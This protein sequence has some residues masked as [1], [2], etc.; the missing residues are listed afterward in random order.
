[1]PREVCLTKTLW[2]R[3]WQALGTLCPVDRV[4]MVFMAILLSYMAVSILSGHAASQDTNTVDVMVRTS[5]SAIFGYFISGNF[6]KTAPQSSS[7]GNAAPSAPAVAAEDTPAAPSCA[8]K[9]QIGVVSLIGMFCLLLLLLCEKSAAATPKH[10][11]T[12]SQL[13]DFVAA[14]IG[15]LI[16]CKKQ[17]S[18]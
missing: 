16:S 5:A 14:C 4:L 12:V 15:F 1:M 9:L 7:P 10:A 13:R 2:N 8:G 18:N 17:P 11:A 6:Q 3:L